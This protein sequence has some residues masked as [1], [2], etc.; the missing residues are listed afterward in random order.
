MSASTQLPIPPSPYVARGRFVSVE[1]GFNITRTALE[2]C[3]F[4]AEC[5]AAFDPATPTGS[6][7]LD[8]SRTLAT[9]WPATT[10]IMLARYLRVR[11][12]DELQAR[13][14][15]GGA[16]HVV[17]R[18][19]G[20]WQ[21]GGEGFDW[22]QGDIF[23]L[24]GGIASTYRATAD[25]VVYCVTNEPL[26]AFERAGLAPTSQVVPVLYPAAHIAEQMDLLARKTM[27]PETPGRA[28][29]LS[30]E[31]LAREKTA[32]SSL[33]ATFNLV[34]PGEWQRPHRHCAA[35]LVLVLRA[36]G[37]HST[38]GGK[39]LDWQ[40]DT[41]VLTPAL[42]PHTHRNEGNEPALAF[43]VQDGGLHYYART[44]DFSFAD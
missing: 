20:T 24:P 6:I 36:G 30:S 31:A 27:T 22:Q 23:I 5:T 43:I 40:P 42:E 41:V 12:G 18:G 7:V 16:I 33:T 9:A 15:C 35:A 14:I 19:S 34:L 28:V 38:I 11:A 25:S 10:P 17:L 1:D 4:Q 39:R 32:L 2:P 26:F 13:F 37:C 21:A 29:N 44:M 3:T 8:R